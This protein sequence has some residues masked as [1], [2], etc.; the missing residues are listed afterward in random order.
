M[1]GARKAGEKREKTW[2]NGKRCDGFFPFFYFLEENARSGAKSGGKILTSAAK[3]CIIQDKDPL[4]PAA[5]LFAGQGGEARSDTMEKLLLDCTLRDGGY[6]NDWKFGRDTIVNIFERL[7]SAGTDIIEVGFLDERRP[8]DPDRSIM[9]DTDAVE[10]IYGG[11]DRGKSMTVAMIDYGTCSTEHIRPAAE[12]WLDG[13]R[14]IFKKNIMEEAFSYCAEIKALGYKVFAQAVSITSYTEEELLRFIGYANA[15]KPYA[16]S[17]VDTYGL[18]HQTDLLKVTSVMDGHLDEG[19]SLGYHAHNNFQMGYANAIS[20]L[21][22]GRR[23]LVVDG[24]LYGM[25]KSAGNAPL[26][27][28]AMYMNAHEGGHYDINQ[29]LEA[30]QTGVMEFYKKRPWGYNLFFYVAASNKVHPNYVSFLMNKRTLSVTEQNEL[31][32]RIPEEKKLLYDPKCIERLYLEYQKTECNDERDMAELA[33]RLRGKEIFVFGP[34]SSVLTCRGQIEKFL[35]ERKP[36][37]FAINCLPSYCKPDYIFVS[38]SQRYLQLSGRLAE[39]E[40]AGIRL[41]AASNVT[42]T[43]G[44]FDYT[45]NY[46][47]LI[48]EGAEYPDNS[49]R[50]LLKAFERISPGKVF[51]AGF[52]GYTPDTV[53]YFDVSMEYSFVKERAEAFNEYGRKFLSESMKRLSL[54]FVTPSHYLENR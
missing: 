44:R 10:K 14:V 51:L 39:R 22:S 37:V 35:A 46:G 9:P 20:F 1:C 32:S 43:R 25:G 23:R 12:S 40:N 47:A 52:D 49:L 34:G 30:I 31:L 5:A 16:V 19:I 8:F 3:D 53:N 27:L 28:L 29:M 17:M 38:N 48:D 2:K 6:V 15:V 24:T 7:V 18:L 26:E 11:L 21:S 42:R 4:C 41:I 36:V 33:A 50:M 13:I 54:E 45:L